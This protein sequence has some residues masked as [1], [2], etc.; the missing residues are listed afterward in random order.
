[1]TSSILICWKL[2][3]SVQHSEVY[4]RRSE[5]T[6]KATVN[7]YHLCFLQIRLLVIKVPPT[8]P[9]NNDRSSLID[10]NDVT[11]VVEDANVTLICGWVIEAEFRSKIWIWCLVKSCILKVDVLSGQEAKFWIEFK[12]PLP[13]SIVLLTMLKTQL[14]FAL[15]PVL[16]H[17][18]TLF[19]SPRH[20]INNVKATANFLSH[21]LAN[22]GRETVARV[23]LEWLVCSD[24]LPIFF[25]GSKNAL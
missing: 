23:F 6:W 14:P 15:V 25:D 3:A 12:H 21:S 13:W 7:I 22:A 10:L 18:I 8:S 17:S 9:K 1:M 20:I 5:T 19:Q 24:Q 16:V 4:R 2:H 11:L